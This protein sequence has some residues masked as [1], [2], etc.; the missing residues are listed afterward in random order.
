[1][2]LLSLPFMQNALLAA[3][4]ASV[5]CGVIGTLVVCNRLTFLAGGA[6]H[7]AYG[8]IGLAFACGLPVLLCTV[9]FTFIASLLMAAIMLHGS[10]KGEQGN[11]SGSETAL[12][13]PCAAG[14]A[15]GSIPTALTPREGAA[16]LAFLF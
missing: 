11:G 16:L 1:M 4:L 7:A 13:G 14:L 5:A 10:G 8:G 9:G 6:A 15:F 2:E 3:L 12:G